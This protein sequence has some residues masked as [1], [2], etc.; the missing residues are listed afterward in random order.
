[1]KDLIERIE[2]ATLQSAAHG[3]IYQIDESC[4]RILDNQI[5]ILTALKVLLERT[6][7]PLPLGLA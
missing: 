4:A 6:E 2:H 7:M 3:S 5:L 1:M